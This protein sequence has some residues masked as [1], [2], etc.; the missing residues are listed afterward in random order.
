M[1]SRVFAV[2]LAAI[3]LS[4]AWILLGPLG[5]LGSRTAY[6]CSCGRG[7][8]AS[9]DPGP[10]PTA[11]AGPIALQGYSAVF[12]GRVVSSFGAPGGMPV[13]F[14]YERGFVFEVDRVYAGV[15][16][17][18]VIVYSNRAEDGGTCGFPF[19]IGQSYLVYASTYTNFNALS[20]IVCDPTRSV[21]NAATLL[22]QLGPGS[23]P[24]A[25]IWLG[26]INDPAIVFGTATVVFSAAAIAYLVTRRRAAHSSPDQE[27]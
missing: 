17:S 1:R 13:R 12:T 3:A 23:E 18:Q 2:R 21:A 8:S 9:D 25:R 20:T 6:A 19:E 7:L 5:P 24:T 10:A 26:S 11:T 16:T 27:P 15:N 22:A 4:L 14:G